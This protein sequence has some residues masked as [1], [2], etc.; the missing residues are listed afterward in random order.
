MLTAHHRD[1]ADETVLL[2][3]LRGAHLTNLAGMEARSDGF[4]LEGRNASKGVVYFA[5]PMLEVRKKD[6]VDYLAKNSLEWRE[7]ESNQSDEYK[8]NRVRNELM[9]LL[10]E[11]A[12]GEHALQVSGLASTRFAVSPGSFNVLAS[13]L[14]R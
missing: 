10:R 3:L 7:D 12:G 4:D 8:R 1:D 5:K 13:N 11:L 14:R 6:A 9:P 2:K